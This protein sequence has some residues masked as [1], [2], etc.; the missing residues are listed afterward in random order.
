M[1][2]EEFSSLPQYVI[3]FLNYLSVVKSKS[4]LTVL[5]YASDLRLF[6]RFML[7][8]R[9]LDSKDC[10]FEKIAIDFIDIDFIKSIKI[11]DAYAFL[12]YC[13]NERKNNDA[14]IARKVS[15]IRAFF[16]YLFLKIKVI[17]ENPME[18]LELPKKKKSL[19]K[20]LT[21]EES[22]KLLKS[23]EGRDKER[24]YAILVLFLNC[25]LRLSEL[26]SLN[27]SDI[28]TD[29][30]MTV[31]GKGNK[32]RMIYLNE[33][34]VNAVNEYMKVRPVDGVKD[35]KALFL[36]NRKCRISPKTV[37]HI[38]E[39]YI[40]K[41]GLGDRGFSTH[42]L[43][44]TAATL[45]YQQGGVDVLLIKDILG[46]ENLATTEIYTHI[47]NSQLKEAVESNPLNQLKGK[48]P[49]E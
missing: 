22:I 49:A 5:E 31:T 41:S 11:S 21:L 16:K 2:K 3:E 40:E 19:P 29:N 23:V 25:G 39:K 12:S 48:K 6:F 45:M 37:Q 46:H 33:M 24:D 35:K 13:R 20:Y 15:S 7:V 4:E 1:H 47:V 10:D 38:V 36:S 26:C 32:E 43:R 9:G 27:Y 34:C 17:S 14:A 8:Y 42:K 18:E 30:T 44:H 28:N